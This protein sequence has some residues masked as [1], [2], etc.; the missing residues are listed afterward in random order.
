[1]S[2]RTDKNNPVKQWNRNNNNNDIM[3]HKHDEAIFAGDAN[4]E[5][6]NIRAICNRSKLMA[7]LQKYELQVNW[8]S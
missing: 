7:T 5:Y 3:A 6:P 1:M 2:D 8:G 4:F